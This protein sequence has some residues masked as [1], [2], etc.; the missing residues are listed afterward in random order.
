M[1][2]FKKRGKAAEEMPLKDSLPDFVDALLA[3]ADLDNMEETDPLTA[4]SKTH[5][6][7]DQAIELMEKLPKDKNELVVSVVMATLA[8]ANVDVDAVIADAQNKVES[9]QQRIARLGEEMTDLKSRIA[10]KETETAEAQTA[11]NQTLLV[12]KLLQQSATV[13]YPIAVINKPQA[14]PP[15]VAHTSSEETD[16]THKKSQFA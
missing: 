15:P 9:I 4:L 1:S 5:Y 7:I 11:L 14:V 2:L 6:G 8:S 16:K 3:E 13:T 12:K 10:R